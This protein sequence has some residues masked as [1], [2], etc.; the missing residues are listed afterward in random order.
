MEIKNSE[1]DISRAQAL[2]SELPNANNISQS[3]VSLRIV[4]LQNTLSNYESS[5]TALRNQKM[6]LKF[7]LANAKDFK[8]FDASIKPKH[9]VGPKKKQNVLIAGM[10]SLMFGVFL[11]FFMEFWQKGKK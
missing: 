8:V 4:L 5:L 2:I 7:S 11:A 3:D 9:P 6:G 1:G 10:L